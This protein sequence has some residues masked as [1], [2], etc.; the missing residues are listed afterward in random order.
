MSKRFI[1]IIQ[2]PM[3]SG[4]S[5]VAK[6]LISKYPELFHASGDNIKWF[7]SDYS[8]EKYSG[9]G[10][11]TRL[12]SSL[13]SQA[14]LESLS[15]L[16]E[17]N[18]GLQ[19]DVKIFSDIAEK[20]EFNFIQVNIEAPYNVLLDR[21]NKRVEDAL[22]KKTNIS[23][24]TEENMKKRYEGYQEFKDKTLPTFDSSKMSPEKIADEI[25]SLI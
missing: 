23:V 17:G 12:L 13:V 16:I 11:I 4:K 5:S 20:N 6:I 25:Q 1:L 3:C 7:I 22:E 24:K 15:V 10:I 8:A 9:K 21:F 14:V 2:G 18:V 19:K